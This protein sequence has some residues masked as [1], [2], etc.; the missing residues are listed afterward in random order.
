MTD[1]FGG[2]ITGSKSNEQSMEFLQ[3]TLKQEGI[4]SRQESFTF[5]GWVRK[6]DE[7][8]LLEPINRPLRTI[9]LGYV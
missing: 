8:L 5:P 6:D 9:A 1:R 2:R 3:E 4:P 7:A